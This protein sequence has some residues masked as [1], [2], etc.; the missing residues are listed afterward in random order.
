MSL[1]TIKK[2][3]KYKL[4]ATGNYDDDL[5][6]MAIIN[7]SLNQDIQTLITALERAMEGLK[8]YELIRINHHGFYAKE[9]LSDVEKLLGEDR[10]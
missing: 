2:R 6:K 1:E 4:V 9:A 7:E 3:L 10:P 5:I 8:E